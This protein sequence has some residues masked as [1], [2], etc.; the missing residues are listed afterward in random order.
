MAAFTFFQARTS[1][2]VCASEAALVSPSL[3][4]RVVGRAVAGKDVVSQP[5]WQQLHVS[6]K[7]PNLTGSAFL[8]TLVS[9]LRPT[10]ACV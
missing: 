3:E 5:S 8:H 9:S 4:C 6:G 7:L 1:P 2:Y 10:L